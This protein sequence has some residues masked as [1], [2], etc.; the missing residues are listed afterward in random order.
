[1]FDF[2]SDNA[3]ITKENGASEY[4]SR[5]VCGESIFDNN[6]ARAITKR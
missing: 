3:V 6:N 1:M 5:C 4:V 2:I